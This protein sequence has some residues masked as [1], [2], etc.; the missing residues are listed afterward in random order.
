MLRL[1]F[2]RLAVF[3]CPLMLT[4]VAGVVA[5]GA[6]AQEAAASG[7]AS[8][9]PRVG[10]VLA[11]GGARGGAHV[12][13]LKVLEEMRIPIDCI[14]GTSMGAL[15]GGGYASG[16]P[17]KDIEQFVRH[18]NWKAVVG[19]VGNRPLETPEQKRFD[20]A[21]GALELGLRGGSVYP[22][23]GAIP[24]SGIEDLLRGYVAR[25]RL[26]PDFDK[27]PIPFRAVATD[28]LTGNMVVLDHGDI[29][30]AMRAS[31]AVPGAFAPVITDQYVLSDGFVVR[32]LPIDVARNTC[33]DVIIA[34]NL[35]K[36]P[37][38]REQ[39]LRPSSLMSRSNDVMSEA[40]ERI[41]LQTLTSRDVRIDVILGDIGAGDF[42]RT[43]DTI[44]LGEKAARAAAG[45]LAA[46]SV[47]EQDYAAWRQRVTVRQDI[48]TQIAAVEF[49]GLKRVNPEYLRTLTTV[50]AGDTADI[51]AISRDAARLA[52]VDGL[53][54]VEYKLSGNP[55]NPV[56]VWQPREQQNGP[57]YLRPNGGLYGAGNGD[58]LFEVG[59]E[60]VR[61]WINS[62]GAEWR[63]RLQIGSNSLVQT[64]LYQPIN[65]AQTFFIEPGLLARRS[66]EDVFNDGD[67]IARYKF[68]DI[69]GQLDVGAN[70]GHDGQVRGGYFATKRRTEVDIGTPLLPE[71]EATDAGLAATATYDSREAESF[72]MHGLAAG[73]QYFRSAGS[74]GADRDWQRIEAAARKNVP[75][76]KMLLWF[77]AAGGTDLGSA[78]PADRAFS[79]GGPQSFPGYSPGEIRARRYWTVDG[80][81]LWSLADILSILSQ[82]LY[83]GLK[84]EAG[85]VYQRVD[86]VPDGT[87]Y[88]VSAFFGGRT[89]IGTLTFGAGWATGST[90]FWVTLGTPVGSGTILNQPLFR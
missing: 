55:D 15:V 22:P 48:Q 11:G 32:N 46:L 33:A 16:M 76:G 23:S 42:E 8:E 52:V 31:M 70:L 54:G 38:T 49:E 63:N 88:G 39:L 25:A 61:R 19:G 71:G 6:A 69:G 34:V 80:A 18:V 58:F 57:D 51:T 20:A 5:R 50:H 47:S 37:V 83:G 78:L 79:L 77:T 59:V 24:T 3:C 29:A 43:P 60:H 26:V 4:V 13:V 86:P 44:D 65:I 1:I 89:P 66:L 40:N 84:L 85:R 56:L 27:L 9:R 72:A 21:T 36:E 67:R 35:A 73:L 87:L 45:R 14:A 64:M 41:Q 28:M 10:L 17:A 74:L 30:T 68:Y 90:A 7:A 62:Y 53:D 12:G 81:F 82:K 75:A 2:A